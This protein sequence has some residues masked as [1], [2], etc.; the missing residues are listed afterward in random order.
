M[1]NKSVPIICFGPPKTS[2]SFIYRALISCTKYRQMAV[3]EWRY[4][5]PLYL[6]GPLGYVDRF[7]V[8]HDTQEFHSTWGPIYHSYVE[9]L[10]FL[11]NKPSNHVVLSQLRHTQSLIFDHHDISSYLNLFDAGDDSFLVDLD[12]LNHTVSLDFI[13]R[14]SNACPEALFF[15]GVRAFLPHLTSLIFELFIWFRQENI[16]TL[17]APLG[18]KNISDCSIEGFQEY[19]VFILSDLK[20]YYETLMPEEVEEIDLK[21][22]AALILRK[23]NQIDRED[24]I[25]AQSALLYLH[26]N[27]FF[28]LRKLSSVS[29]GRESVFYYYSPNVSATIPVLISWLQS[30]GVDVGES[31]V[32]IDM[33]RVRE[34]D[35]D[36][37]SRIF[38]SEYI[39]ELML[40]IEKA[41]RDYHFGKIQ[42]SL[43][44]ILFPEINFRDSWHETCRYMDQSSQLTRIA[45]I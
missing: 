40:S 19:L 24:M 33:P 42:D 11:E 14:L 45:F 26:T 25:A 4:L 13:E 2:T 20:R 23:P 12:P 38:R 18:N 6:Y 22:S 44:D 3:K 37:I 15:S 41:S 36:L 10:K 29:S 27:M 30:K 7:G 35:E 21:I 39:R 31:E 8:R 28:R 9:H 34:S 1:K 17:D 16:G 32:K 43:H 5:R